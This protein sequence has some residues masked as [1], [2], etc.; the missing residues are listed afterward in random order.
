MILQALAWYVVVALGGGVALGALRRLGLGT[1]AS[2]AVA[3][4]SLWTVAGYVAWIAGW[5]GVSRWWWIGL[6]ALGAIG[7]WGRRGFAGLQVKA[8]A[9]PELVGLGAFLLLGFLRL[10]SMAVTAT[11]KPMDLAI[12]STLLRPGT[13]PPNDPW[14]AGLTLPYYY[15]GFAPWL[16]PAKLIGLA[17]NVVF[18]LLVATVAAVSAQ[19]AWALARALGGSR[20]TGVLASFLVVFLGTFDGWRQLLGGVSVSAIDLWPASRAIKGTITEFPLFTFHLGDLHP[21]LLC[22]PLALVGIFLARVVGTSRSNWIP[23][24]ALASLVYGAAAAANPW[25]ALPIGAAML[26]VAVGDEAGFVR[27]TG[28]GLRIW[29]RIVAVGAAGWLLYLPFWLAFHP[30]TEG[31]GIVTTPTRT[32]EMIL[33]LGGALIPVALV[34]WEL[35]WRWGGVDTARRRFTRA[36]WLAG[37]VLVTILTKRPLLGL[38]LGAGAVVAVTAARGRMRRIRPALAVTLVPLALLGLMEILYFKDPYGTEFYRMNT[39]F[40]ATHMAFTLLAVVAPV[41][42]GWLR[43]RRAAL[44]VAGAALLVAAGVPQL[45][46]LAT[47]AAGTAHPDWSGLG[48]MAPGDADAAAWLRGRPPGTVIVEAI[49]NAYSDAARMSSASGVPA[50]LGWDN[51]ESVWRG[52]KIGPETGR[53][54]ALVEQLYRCG[55]SAQARR[56]A[57]ELGARYVVV[58]GVESRTYPEAGL[59]AVLAVGPAAFR[60]E[61]CTVVEVTP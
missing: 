1:G 31:F 14:L 45:A 21:H 16:L 57:Q 23:A 36:V 15:W 39:V 7:W 10:S 24:A 25:C 13:I 12:L 56:I 44:A 20:R 5:A 61:A 59:R 58:G 52:G 33:L 19:A 42:L 53:R 41:L 29:A 18:N 51:H 28:P 3:R 54:K 43:H 48:W 22:V 60:S 40:K 11:E 27:P 49:G 4:V 38:V 35:S 6:L 8:L 17:P 55:D 34:G 50:V 26:L 30:P 37:M 9:E 2:W 32:G 46:A 47:R